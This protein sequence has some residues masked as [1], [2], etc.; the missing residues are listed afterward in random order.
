VERCLVC[1]TER[2]SL[3]VL[4]AAAPEVTLG[5]SIPRLR[6]DPTASARTRYAALAA[7]AAARR[8]LPALLARGVRRGQMDAVMI[9]W[10][11]VSPQLVRAVRGA[12]GELYVWTVDDPVLLARLEALGVDAVITNDPRLFRDDVTERGRDRSTAPGGT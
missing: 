1:S 8:V 4:R 10:R 11:L 9:H 3:R 7:A 5:L 2:A 6:K 12:G